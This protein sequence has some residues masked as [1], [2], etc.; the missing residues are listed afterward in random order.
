MHQHTLLNEVCKIYFFTNYFLYLQCF[1]CISQTIASQFDNVEDPF[2][3]L[4]NLQRLR[5]VC[6]KE[7]GF[8]N[9]NFMRSIKTFSCAIKP[10]LF[11]GE[12]GIQINEE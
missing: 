4:A 11:A 1:Q 7:L 2:L 9:E 8:G 10:K 3:M 6:P 12:M 5:S